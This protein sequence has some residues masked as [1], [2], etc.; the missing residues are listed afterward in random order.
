MIEFHNGK[1]LL[2]KNMENVMDKFKKII[3][4]GSKGG[5]YMFVQD[6]YCRA[7]QY[8]GKEVYWL[9][10]NDNFSED[11]FDDSLIISDHAYVNSK[12][13]LR[14][15]STYYMY[16]I[17]NKGSTPQD[18]RVN[19]YL[20]KVGRLIEHRL[21]NNWG[22][23]EYEDDRWEYKFEKE[24]CIEL[25]NK[26]SFFEK[27]DD[28]DII[29]SYWG[30]DLLPHEINFEDRFT[31]FKEPKFA[32][33]C[34][35]ITTH[36]W[37]DVN[38]ANYHLWKSFAEECH[39]NGVMFL[40]NDTGR[41]QMSPLDIKTVTLQSF[42]PIDIRAKIHLSNRYVPCRAFKNA[43]YGQLVI[44]NSKGTYDF[45]EGDAAYSDDLV[46][47]FHIASEMQNNPKTKDI[48]LRQ[49]IRVKDRYTYVSH[50]LDLFKALEM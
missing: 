1:N 10:H 30:T 41:T 24:K 5:T 33:M 22:V 21:Q 17:G 46:E 7:A 35:T 20:G 42:L 23:D 16:Y 14:K 38:N 27:G 26:S 18:P 49:M 37:G 25:P 32:F 44:T 36:G 40:H 11:F 50:L 39:K 15:S 12:M 28:Y 8:L 31:P 3:V 34:G 2:K 29:Y 6:A 45:F 13:P 9:D 19:Y 43:S 48:I 47:L 4:W